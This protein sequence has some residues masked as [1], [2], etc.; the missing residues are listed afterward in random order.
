MK[1]KKNKQMTNNNNETAWPFT[2]WN[3]NNVNTLN[4]NPLNTNP[5]NAWNVAPFTN[6][7][8]NTVLTTFANA[9]S[10]TPAT[11]A[12]E[13]TE[14]YVFEIAAPGYSTDSFELSY[15]YPT[16]TLKASTA[17]TDRPTYSY[18]EFNYS[19]FTRE[20]NLPNNADATDARAKYENGILTVMVPKTTTTNQKT[21]KIS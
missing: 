11:N 12:Y 4:T 20:F 16:L 7:P 13:N 6:A 3:S 18:R 1:Q 21:I 15:V 8:L 14:S 10:N 2:A 17:K 5:F 19:A 9:T